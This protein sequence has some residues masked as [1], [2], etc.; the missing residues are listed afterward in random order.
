MYASKASSKKRGEESSSSDD[1]EESD[2]S[3]DEDE[4]IP[5]YGLKIRSSVSEQMQIELKQALR[6]VFKIS[7]A[8]ATF[9]EPVNLALSRCEHLLIFDFL[10]QNEKV[11]KIRAKLEG[12]MHSTP[13]SEVPTVASGSSKN[14]S[15]KS[16]SA[17]SGSSAAVGKNNNNNQQHASPQQQRFEA[18]C[19]LL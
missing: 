9:T 17:S 4:N 10:Q 18:Q 14:D 2:S 11:K 3:D 16:S 19:F 6:Q 15:K 1:D 7:V 8:K 5:S 12:A 13:H